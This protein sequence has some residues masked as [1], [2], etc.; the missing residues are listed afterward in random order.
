MQT[1]VRRPPK[2]GRPAL[3]CPSLTGDAAAL[4][5]VLALTWELAAADP[6]R[7]QRAAA[8][9]TIV[10]RNGAAQARVFSGSAI[11]EAF[12]CAG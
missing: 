3:N 2:D 1:F 12:T 5:S 9:A 7:L 8:A 10:S 11:G 6:K 4:P